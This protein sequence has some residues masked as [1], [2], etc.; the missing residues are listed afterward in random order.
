[1]ENKKLLLILISQAIF[2]TKINIRVFIS[3]YLRIDKRWRLYGDI[4]AFSFLQV[5]NY[6]SKF[7]RSGIF[8]KTVR[9][10]SSQISTKS[11]IF[12]FLV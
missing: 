5:Q 2:K 11:P 12:D 3:N 1:M 10:R 9:C 8:L 4:N 7:I 6:F